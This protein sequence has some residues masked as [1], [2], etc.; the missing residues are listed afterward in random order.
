MG[1]FKE[2]STQEALRSQA[3]EKAR[4]IWDSLCRDFEKNK[5]PIEFNFKENVK[6]IFQNEYFISK[7]HYI[8]PYPGKI[9]PYIPA[10]LLSVPQLCPADGIILDPFS[11]SGTIL[12]ES[13]IHPLFKRDAYGVEINPLGRLISKVKTTPLLEE[14]IEKRAKS[15]VE[16]LSCKDLSLTDNRFFENISFWFSPRSIKRLSN[17]AVHIDDLK[18]DD[19]KDFFYLCFSSIIRRV[20]LADPF[21]PPP[22]KLNINKY[23]KSPDK[24]KF[25]QEYSQIAQNAN[26]KNLIK[27]AVS[28]NKVKILILND[29]GNTHNSISAASIIWDNAKSINRGKLSLKG[30]LHKKYSRRLKDYSIDLIITSPPY[31]TAQKYIRTHKLEIQWLDMLSNEAICALQE[32]IVGAERV[33]YKRFNTSD[34]IGVSSIDTLISWVISRSRERA[35]AIFCYFE[36]MKKALIEMRRVLKNRGFCVIVVG[37]NHVLG[38]YI[39]THK[40][41][42]DLSIDVG[43]ELKVILKDMIR[44]RGM[45][46]KRH[47]S[48]GLIKEEY[49]IVLQ[50]RV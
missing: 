17:L 24:F 43:F 4:Y 2:T 45:I 47:N 9:F 5:T 31:L 22:V 3:I 30:N 33:S 25:L 10:F 48:G 1:N 36:D 20:S 49:V 15:I 23:K 13:I 32:N 35:A 44:G 41:L 14:E 12:L 26:I 27:A 46:T 37:N 8:H 28:Q 7:A 21:I 39:E 6:D 38:K 19:Y 42:T 34:S 11:G 16:K 18:D 50:N 29:V 40:L